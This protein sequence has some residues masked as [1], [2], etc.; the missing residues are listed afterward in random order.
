MFSHT[1]LTEAHRFSIYNRKTLEKSK[2]CG[3]FYCEKIYSPSEITDWIDSG[4]TAECPYCGTDSVI[5]SGSGY[6]ITEE[7]LKAMRKRWFW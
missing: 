4:T 2:S 7:F 5:G 6:P 1:D 3:C